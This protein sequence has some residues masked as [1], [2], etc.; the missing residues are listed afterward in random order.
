MDDI[1]L[2]NFIVR[3]DGRVFV[4][5]FAFA[6]FRENGVSDQQWKEKVASMEEELLTKI[7]LDEKGLRDKTPPDPYF[8]NGCGYRLFNREIEKSRESWV[9]KYYELV[10]DPDDFEYRVSDD[11]EEYIFELSNWNLKQDAVNKRKTYLESLNS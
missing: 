9:S 7:F 3:G 6:S 5:D 2:P 8:T 10:D 1:R 4:F 11:G